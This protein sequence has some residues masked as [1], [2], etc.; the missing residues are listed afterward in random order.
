LTELVPRIDHTKAVLLARKL[1]QLPLIKPYLTSVQEN[2]VAAVNEALNQL[3]IDEEDYDALRKSIDTYDNFDNIALAQKVEKLELLEFKRIAAYLYK[4]NKRWQ[5]SVQLSKNE[6][7]FKDAIETASDSHDQQV[8]E[9][10][11]AY[12]VENKMPEC[13]AATLYS[14]YDL[15]R[16][17]T[18]LELAWRSGIIDYTMPYLVQ[19]LR[20][21]IPKI[22][23][24]E[25]KT[26]E[27]E[28][29][30][31]AKEDGKDTVVPTDFTPS[32]GQVGSA[33]A[34]YMTAPMAY[35]SGG[36]MPGQI[37]AVGMPHPMSA[38]YPVAFPGSFPVP[39]QGA[40]PPQFGSVPKDVAFFP[41]GFNK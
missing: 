12:F 18:A 39:F 21:Y 32:M 16:P 29:K 14:C 25:K 30:A 40:F 11:L 3:Y 13:F 28:E 27:A 20:E 9:N 5:E 38:G 22:D 34:N 4:K 1:V 37:P 7:L 33:P 23:K 31:K 24:L 41:T 15:I 19:V 26:K 17:D 36:I 35:P 6:K 8:A 2:N 10:L